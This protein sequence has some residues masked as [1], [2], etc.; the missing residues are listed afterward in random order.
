MRR[1]P[2]REEVLTVDDLGD[3]DVDLEAGTATVLRV[4]GYQRRTTLLATID[5]NGYVRELD[6]RRRVVDVDWPADVESVA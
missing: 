3:Y 6:D 5:E 2:D 4:H 1:G